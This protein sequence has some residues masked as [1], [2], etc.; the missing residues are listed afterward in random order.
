MSE[1]RY[2]IE[3]DG[4]KYAWIHEHCCCFGH[5]GSDRLEVN[6]EPYGQVDNPALCGFITSLIDEVKEARN[7]KT[8]VSTEDEVPIMLY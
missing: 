1:T 6:G 2:E 5:C 4:T 7:A 8:A 3:I